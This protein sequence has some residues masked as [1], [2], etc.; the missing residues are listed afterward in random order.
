MKR[1]AV[2]LERR[3]MGQAPMASCWMRPSKGES[4]NNWCLFKGSNSLPGLWMSLIDKFIERFLGTGY[5]SFVPNPSEIARFESL[6]R[7][8]RRGRYEENM[9]IVWRRRRRRWRRRRRR[10]DGKVG[11][12]E[13]LTVMK[14]VKGSLHGRFGNDRKKEKV[15]I[16]TFGDVRTLC[17]HQGANNSPSNVQ[18]LTFCHLYDT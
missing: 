9:K 2:V 15:F 3:V 7:C 17:H 1:Q 16:A 8:G 4:L 6:R 13:P 14:L 12:I 11:K 5:K 10:L 18:Q